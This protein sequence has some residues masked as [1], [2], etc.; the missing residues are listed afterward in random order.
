MKFVFFR[1][2][3]PRQFSYKPR[4]YDEKKEALENLKKKYSGEQS[5]E[6]YSPD[7]REKLRSSWKIKE[8]RTGNITRTTLLIY[9]VIAALILYYIFFS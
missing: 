7:F 4:Y 9:F 8:K 2:P 1:T 5:K 6:G 3:K